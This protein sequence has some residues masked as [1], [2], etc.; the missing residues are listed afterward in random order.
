[1]Q[2]IENLGTTIFL[3]DFHTLKKLNQDPYFQ[4]FAPQIPVLRQLIQLSEF[5][6]FIK[7][8]SLPKRKKQKCGKNVGLSATEEV[9]NPE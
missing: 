9:N 7:I 8:L 4:P 6:V 2:F 3:L 1:M 5:R